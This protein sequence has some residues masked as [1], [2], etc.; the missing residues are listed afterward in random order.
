MLL[1]LVALLT[2]VAYVLLLYMFTPR[3]AMAKEDKGKCGSCRYYED[4]ACK[5]YPPDR[6]YTGP[7]HHGGKG[8]D[9][10]VWPIVRPTVDWCGEHEKRK[11]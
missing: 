8:L 9:V 11:E 2:P 6:V 10:T 1:T 5:R 7:D 4:Q 3:K